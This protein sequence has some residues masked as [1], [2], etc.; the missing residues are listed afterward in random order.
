MKLSEQ[1]KE[2]IYNHKM[3]YNCDCMDGEDAV[4]FYDLTECYEFERSDFEDAVIATPLEFYNLR[5]SIWNAY[6]LLK[7]DEPELALYHV[8]EASHR[9]AK[10]AKTSGCD[11][12]PE[13]LELYDEDKEIRLTVNEAKNL[14]RILHENAPYLDCLYESSKDDYLFLQEITERIEQR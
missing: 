7:A 14:M 9:A 11:Y 2:R 6:G 5:A 8:K 10:I 13:S 3:T 1:G 4:G 12:E